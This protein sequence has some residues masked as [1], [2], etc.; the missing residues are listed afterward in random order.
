MATGG[1]PDWPTLAVIV[2]LFEMLA[3]IALALGLGTRWAAL[4]LAAFTVVATLLF[5][6]YWAAP[7]D[8]QMVQQLLFLKN[9][10]V[11]GGLLI[12]ATSES[13]PWSVDARRRPH[14]ALPPP[15]QF[16]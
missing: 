14:D 9:L 10:A 7:A 16:T 4:S 3:G 2:G 11:I 6:A 5:H 12:I 8:H 1:L 15:R 13:G